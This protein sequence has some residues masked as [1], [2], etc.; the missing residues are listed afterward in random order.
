VKPISLS[1]GCR[2]SVTKLH[3][4]LKHNG[5][6]KTRNCTIAFPCFLVEQHSYTASLLP[7]EAMRKPAEKLKFKYS[8]IPEGPYLTC[9]S[10]H[11]KEQQI[12]H[13]F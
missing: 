12:Y 3:L 13:T 10:T 8:S 1:H 5:R 7:E 4:Y 11:L 9:L 2:L 6:G